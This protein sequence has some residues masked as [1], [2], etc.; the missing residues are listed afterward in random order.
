MSNIVL[1]APWY[2]PRCCPTYPLR[3]SGTDAASSLS[4]GDL[5][6]A[7]R[8]ETAETDGACGFQRDPAGGVLHRDRSAAR[9]APLHAPGSLLSHPDRTLWRP[10]VLLGLH[11]AA[12]YRRVRV[13]SERKSGCA[14]VYVRESAV[15][16]ECVKES[17]PV[18]ET[19][20]R[21]SV[22]ICLCMRYGMPGTE[23]GCLLCVCSGMPGTELCYLLCDARYWSMLSAMRCPVLTQHAISLQ[24]Q[25]TLVFFLMSFHLV[26]MFNLSP[27]RPR[28]P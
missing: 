6:D 17:L 20:V 4:S 5:R 13:C 14:R 1:P 21:C 12:A 8:A 9:E 15:V 28:A 10:P 22:S 11:Q 25:T 3:E 19:L 16:C 2:H 27:G 26:D 24:S 18:R 23:L 7:P